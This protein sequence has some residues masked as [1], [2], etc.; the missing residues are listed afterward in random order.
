MRNTI[1][2]F[3]TLIT[4]SSLLAGCANDLSTDNYTSE[5]TFNLTMEG[6]I[7]SA[8]PVNIDK[9]PL[10]TNAAGMVVGGATGALLTSKSDPA[11]MIGAGLVGA[12]LGA[13]A[14]SKLKSSKGFEYIIKVDVSKLKHDAGDLHFTNPTIKNAVAS[15]KTNGLIT[16]VQGKDVI[17]QKGQPVYV[18]YS[19]NRTRVVPAN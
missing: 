3:F 13:L 12:G 16:V 18:I 8:R 10:G 1:V 14:E 5:S 19:D 11:V 2:K 7:I 15:A 9:K 17:L 4:L 6:I